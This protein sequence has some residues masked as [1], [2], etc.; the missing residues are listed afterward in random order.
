MQQIK[1]AQPSKW[2]LETVIEPPH[3]QKRHIKRF[4]VKRNKRMRPRHYGRD[5]SQQPSFDREARKHKLPDMKAPS[6][7][8]PKSNH[9]RHGTRAP[10]KPGRL[11]VKEE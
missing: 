8:A 6:L 4:P 5:R 7:E 1:V 2:S 11:Q 9:K 3:L 10:A